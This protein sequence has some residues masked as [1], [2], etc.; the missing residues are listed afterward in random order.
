MQQNNQ[1]KILRILKAALPGTVILIFFVLGGVILAFFL[2]WGDI[3]FDILDWSQEGPRYL[4]LK[5]ALQE[6]RLPLHIDS[7]M[8]ET[9]RFLGIPDT[10][11]VPQ[12]FLL[13]WLTPGQFILV[14]VL[15]NYSLGFYFL[16]RLKH[17]LRWTLPTFLVVVPLT[18]LNGFLLSHL[19]VGH[20]MWVNAF[21]L[22]WLVILC[23]NFPQEKIN[24]RWILQFS[25]FSLVLFLQGGFHFA[26]WSWGFLLVHA[27][28]K[29]STIKTGLVAVLFAALISMVRILPASISFYASERRF[30]AGFRSLND[31]VSAL[32]QLQLPE[33]SQVLLNSG[34]PNWETNFYIGLLGGLFVLLFGIILPIAK[35]NSKSLF[36][37]YWIPIIILT[38]LSIGQVFRVTNLLPLPLVHAERV[39]SR[40]F[41]LPFL[42]LV[43]I[44]G[45]HFNLWWQNFKGQPKRWLVLSAGILILLHDLV[46]NARLWRVDRMATLYEKINV[47]LTGDVLTKPDP[48]Y[49]TALIFGA[50]ITLITLVVLILLAL[51]TN[52]SKK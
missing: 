9:D 3:P 25:L 38:V 13:L 37:R 20:S 45:D 19:S 33:E 49:F 24:W 14:N 29:K 22:P 42:F 28:T 4:F 44:A 8:V 50:A 1:N 12:S 7:P 31:L 46:Q 41:Y 10:L 52:Q 32:I 26:L 47:P 6:K 48:A 23:L 15:L 43:V 11:L 39:S 36:R 21:L 51:R 18:T 17:E 34:L 2:N 16:L 35:K 40:F 5:N 27:L 30:I